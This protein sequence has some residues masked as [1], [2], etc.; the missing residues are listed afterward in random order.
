M[1]VYGMCAE[2]IFRQFLDLDTEPPFERTAVGQTGVPDV[3]GDPSTGRPSFEVKVATFIYPSALRNGHTW[4]GQEARAECV[5]I[6][7]AVRC[8]TWPQVKVAEFERGQ[9]EE[10]MATCAAGR[11]GHR[12]FIHVKGWLPMPDVRLFTRESGKGHRGHSYKV[13][14][15]ALHCPEKIPG[16]RTIE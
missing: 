16:V 13:P 7:H 11:C 2:V 12:H 4:V 3:E 8:P 9:A 5:L 6:N 1:N 10:L 14:L 15:S